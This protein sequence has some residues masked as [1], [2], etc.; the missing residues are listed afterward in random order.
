MIMVE[1]T[2]RVKTEKKPLKSQKTAKKRLKV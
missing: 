2:T 1:W